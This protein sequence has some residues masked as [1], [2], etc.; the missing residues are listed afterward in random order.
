MKTLRT[1][2]KMICVALCFSLAFG[3]GACTAL[4]VLADPF[5][6]L[7]FIAI[8]ALLAFLFGW[9]GTLIIRSIPKSDMGLEVRSVDE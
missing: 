5:D 8:G 6:N 2:F 1:V 3:F 9:I 4:G 7:A